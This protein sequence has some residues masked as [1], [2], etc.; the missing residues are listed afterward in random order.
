MKQ[1]AGDGQRE[2]VAETRGAGTGEEREESRAS[3]Q[4]IICGAGCACEP[5]VNTSRDRAGASFASAIT[6]P[7]L[8]SLSLQ[9]FLRPLL[10]PTSS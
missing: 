10:D 4:R 1:G 9:S 2:S 5:N 7:N 3:G 8:D 6:R